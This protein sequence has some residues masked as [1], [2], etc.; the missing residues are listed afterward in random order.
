[1]EGCSLL[2]CS[3]NVGSTRCARSQSGFKDAALREEGV[4]ETIWMDQIIDL[5]SSV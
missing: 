2:S 3:W 5:S 1:M 4:V